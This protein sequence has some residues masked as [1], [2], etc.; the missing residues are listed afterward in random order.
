MKPR[1]HKNRRLRPLCGETGPGDG[2]DPRDDARPY[3]PRKV[4]RKTLQLCGQ[5][6]QTLQLVLSAECDDDWLRALD[7]LRV[8][9]GP[10]ASRLLVTVTP[11]DPADTTP[12]SEFL[13]RLQARSG[14]LRSE[15]ARTISR[16]KA[17]LLSFQFV[18]GFSG[19]APS[20][21]GTP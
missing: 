3:D 14:R 6:R 10:D 21:G 20:M 16:R 9:P 11:L 1:S 2:I 15:V 19:S 13:D 4:D 8:A 17:P 12:A 5:V 18:P 7:V